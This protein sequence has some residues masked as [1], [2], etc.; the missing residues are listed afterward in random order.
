MIELA[1]GMSWMIGWFLIAYGYV[2]EKMTNE[3]IQM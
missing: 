1:L 3:K 2:L